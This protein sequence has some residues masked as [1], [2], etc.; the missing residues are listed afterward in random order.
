MYAEEIDGFDR[1]VQERIEALVP[2]MIEEYLRKKLIDENTRIL[3]QEALDALR[4]I[5]SREKG[6]ESGTLFGLHTG[7]ESNDVGNPS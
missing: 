4:S 5:S 7:K 1:R 3:E 6:Y 2:N